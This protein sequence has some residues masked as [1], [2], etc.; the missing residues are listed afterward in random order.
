MQDT[1]VGT[2]DTKLNRKYL[3][4]PSK[5]MFWSGDWPVDN[6]DIVICNQMYEFNMEESYMRESE[7]SQGS[8]LKYE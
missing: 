6:C 5:F 3:L 8:D 1:M 4:H 7:D 2:G